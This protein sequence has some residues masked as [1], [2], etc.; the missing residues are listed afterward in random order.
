MILCYFLSPVEFM[1]CTS[2]LLCSFQYCLWFIFIR[3]FMSFVPILHPSYGLN[4][5]QSLGHWE[6]A[7]N[8]EEAGLLFFSILLSLHDSRKILQC[9]WFLLQFC[10]VRIWGRA[11][12]EL[13]ADRVAWK[14]HLWVSRCYHGSQK[15]YASEEMFSSEIQ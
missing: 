11:L 4:F 1:P 13:C 14:I 3:L 5:V 7:W 2:T 6:R 8:S 10:L 15:A 12:Q 9:L